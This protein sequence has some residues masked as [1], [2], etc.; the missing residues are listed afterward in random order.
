MNLLSLPTEILT[1]IFLHLGVAD[2]YALQ[3][4][5]RLF[6]NLYQ[7]SLE[8]QYAL[9]CQVASVDDNPRCQLSIAS[10]LQMLR[11]R[12][13]AW[14]SLEPTSR[15]TVPVPHESSAHYDMTRSHFCLGKSPLKRSTLLLSPVADGV[16]FYSIQTPSDGSWSVVHAAGLVDFGCC[17]DEHDLLACVSR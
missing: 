15:K 14:R 11:D 9:E 3:S 2:S 16:Q 4:V 13:S 7:S 8:L 10:R 6:R 17:I 1:A 12:E 5:N